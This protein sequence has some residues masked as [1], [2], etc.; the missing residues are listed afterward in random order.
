MCMNQINNNHPFMSVTARRS[1]D[2]CDDKVVSEYEE[3]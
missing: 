3:D 1:L 2:T